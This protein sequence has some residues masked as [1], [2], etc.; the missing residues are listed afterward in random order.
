MKALSSEKTP[1][2]VCKIQLLSKHIDIFGMSIFSVDKCHKEPKS[3]Y[4][5]IGYS[6]SSVYHALAFVRS[7]VSNS[8]C[9]DLC[10]GMGKL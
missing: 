8:T 6:G 5:E 1:K 4:C 2:C 3:Y 7:G 10:H 9:I